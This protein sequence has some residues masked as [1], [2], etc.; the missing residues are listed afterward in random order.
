MFVIGYEGWGS[1]ETL[2]SKLTEAEGAIDGI[3]Q[4]DT[5]FFV[6][7]NLFRGVRAQ[8]ATGLYCLLTCINEGFS[9]INNANFDWLSY[10]TN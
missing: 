6:S 1:R 8:G 7:S 5:G 2:S 10:V 3:L 9:Y 4:I